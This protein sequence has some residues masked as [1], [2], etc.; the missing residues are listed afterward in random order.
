MSRTKN[1]DPVATRQPQIGDDDVEGIGMRI[2]DTFDRVRATCDFLNVFPTFA[3][4]D[5]DA[6]PQ[7]IVVFDD[8][9]AGR[10]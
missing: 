2:G 5:C 3:K 9:D 6:T 7:R 4:R 10:V 8:E 1:R